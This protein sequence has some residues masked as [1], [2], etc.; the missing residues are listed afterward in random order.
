[1]A[2]KS[3]QTERSHVE[4]RPIPE[5]YAGSQF[6]VAVEDQTVSAHTLQRPD[7]SVQK[8]VGRGKPREL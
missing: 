6:L 3:Q 5:E 8:P 1:M 4:I 2:W 7:T